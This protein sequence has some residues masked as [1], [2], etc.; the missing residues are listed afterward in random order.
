[1]NGQ[2][3]SL[4]Q[5][6][7]Y[8]HW[9]EQETIAGRIVDMRAEVGLLSRNI[10]ITSDA[11]QYPGFGGHIMMMEQS[12]LKLDGVEVSRMGQPGRL[13][14]Y[15]I[16][17]HKQDAEGAGSF[18]RNSSVHSAHQRGMVVHQTESLQ[19][20]GNVFYDI[21]GHGVFLEDS[22][23]EVRNRFEN[24]LVMGIRYV[25]RA[26]R[27]S[28]P[29]GDDRAERLSGF[30]ITAAHNTF[31]GNRVAG[32]ENG[33]GFVFPDP[34]RPLPR[35]LW[36]H[37]DGNHRLHMLAFENNA[38]HTI[39]FNAAPPDGGKGVFNLA[40][41]PEEAGSCLRMDAIPYENGT[42]ALNVNITGF[43]AYKCRNAAIWDSNGKAMQNAIVA[44]SRV[45]FHSAQG[46]QRS[47][48][49]EDSVVVAGTRNNPAGRPIAEAL[50]SGPF[51]GPALKED[52]EAAPV[53]LNRVQT[54]GALF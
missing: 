9:G 36:Y 49:V 38:A 15:S 3:I 52:L 7:A 50:T 28:T 12:K 29:D 40:Y 44:D 5:P 2:R 8:R 14:R 46:S 53:Q 27:L 1:M 4:D 48:S 31:I 21:R 47:Y 37:P 22:V 39:G 6:L 41:G 43:T 17:F 19:V 34:D 51:A 33:W 54:I 18:V 24:N 32:V 26:Y 35:E 16:H 13:G 45:A 11:L 20:S 42:P 25:P 23:N 30:W 10:T